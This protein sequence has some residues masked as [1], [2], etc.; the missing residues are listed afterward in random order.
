MSDLILCESRFNIAIYRLTYENPADTRPFFP[1]QNAAP[2]DMDAEVEKVLNSRPVVNA[3][4]TTTNP[5]TT[6]KNAKNNTS[7]VVQLNEGIP[8]AARVNITVMIEFVLDCYQGQWQGMT[9]SGNDSM[10]T[11]MM[12]QCNK[13]KLSQKTND[14]R[15]KCLLEF[16]L[17]NYGHEI[18][19]LILFNHLIG[20]Q[21]K[22]TTNIFVGKSIHSML[23]SF[24]F[25]F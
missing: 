21:P 1:T 25:T 9:K 4:V 22:F 19:E 11:T 12:K 13:K 20:L 7:N 3:G 18:P 10:L 17:S 5:A 16:L 23:L 24:L 2:I 8:V 15:T 14:I 6:G